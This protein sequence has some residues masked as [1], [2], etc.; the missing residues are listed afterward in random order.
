MIKL[1]SRHPH[2]IRVSYA[3]TIYGAA[4]K[5]AVMKVLSN[6]GRIVAGHAVAEFE[7]K[8]AAMFGKKRGIMVNS[9][10]SANL[11]S[12]SILDLAEG[13][14]VITP[15]LTFSTTLAPILQRRLMPV[16]VDVEEGTYVVDVDQVEAKVTKR[17]KALMIPSLIGNIPDLSALQRIAKKHKL[18]L[19][20]D[21]CDTL[22]PAFK[23]KPTGTYTDISTTSFYASHIITAAGGGGMLCLNDPALAERARVMAYWGR[24]S[25]LFGA[26]EKSEEIKKRFAGKLDGEPYDAKFIFSEVGYNFQ[27]TEIQGAFGLEQLKHFKAFKA[28]RQKNFA[29]LLKFFSHYQDRFILPHS[30]SGVDTAWLAFPLTVRPNAGFSRFELAKYLEERDIQTRPIFT[31][32]VTKQP[33]FRDV[34]KNFS[35]R[36]PMTDAVMRGGLLIGCHHGITEKHLEYL[37]YVFREFLNKH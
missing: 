34:L 5:R 22:G 27:P 29:S 20:E 37:Q 12:L 7:K 30:L 2:P 36:F 1:M 6:P 33:G 26:Y 11:V 8:V 25:T 28:R 23:G 32:N 35:G 4:E 21:S 15:A 31:G 17:T 14:E 24:Q 3:T 16:F 19:I 10:S 9:G 18:H 13:S